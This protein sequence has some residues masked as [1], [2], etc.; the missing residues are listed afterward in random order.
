MAG[1]GTA[2]ARYP[3]QQHSTQSRS[4]GSRNFQPHPP[5]H[6][7]MYTPINNISAQLG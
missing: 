3:Y 1:T 7:H 5:S 4:P 6:H 2:S